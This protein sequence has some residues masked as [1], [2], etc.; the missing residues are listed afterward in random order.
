MDCCLSET[1]GE[2]GH[3][4]TQLDWCLPETEGDLAVHS[5]QSGVCLRLEL[6]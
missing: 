5:T 2:L 3:G 6:G 4:S 1:E